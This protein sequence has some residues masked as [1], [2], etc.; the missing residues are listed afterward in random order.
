[1][2]YLILIFGFLILFSI[3]TRKY[4]NPY[5]LFFVFGKKGSGKS[6][7]LVKQALKYKK[8]GFI[9][10]TNMADMCIPGVRYIDVDLLGKFVPEADSALF[11]DEVGMI[12][13]SRNFKA[14]KPE[15]RD[16]F[17]LQRH[18]RV[19]CFLA[20]QTWDIDK[21]LRDLTDRMYLITN[22]ATV[23][24]LVRPVR[25]KIVVTEAT[26][27]SESR[28]SENLKI[29]SIFDWRFTY[30]PKFKKYFDSFLVP[31]TP[32]ISYKEYLTENEILTQTKESYVPLHA[33]LDISD[34]KENKN[35][36]PSHTKGSVTLAKLWRWLRFSLSPI[37]L[38]Q[39]SFLTKGIDYAL[40]LF[41]H[42]NEDALSDPEETQLLIHEFALYLSVIAFVLLALIV[43]LL[44]L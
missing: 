37:P 30:I 42:Y 39:K 24:S 38:I 5:Q 27:D 11:I 15:V 31:D 20:S 8:K 2:T 36:I 9:I 23:F 22:F 32:K 18:Y 6:T 25:R 40:T 19:V 4:K 26:S 34:Y 41:A 28:I 16:F 3:F 12:W 29:S 33:R 44:F 13:D 10:Y 1:M 17:K 7:Y 14:F 35:Y 43:I 21:K